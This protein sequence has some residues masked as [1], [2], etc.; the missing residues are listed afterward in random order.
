MAPEVHG[1]R[2][3]D[4]RRADVWSLGTTILA[5]AVPHMLYMY[6]YYA[7]FT[8]NAQKDARY[9]RYEEL[10]GQIAALRSLINAGL[11][12]WP[13]EWPQPTAIGGLLRSGGYDMPKELP[14]TLL[15]VLDGMLRPEPAERFTAADVHAHLV[16]MLE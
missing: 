14:P 8:A 3:Y 13:A 12:S 2:C 15:M 10:H 4:P 16:M 1:G 11:I 6:G 7:W 9:R 5:L